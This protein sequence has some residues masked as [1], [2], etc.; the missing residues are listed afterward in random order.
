METRRKESS[1]MLFIDPTVLAY[2]VHVWE[3][4]L[5]PYML[6]SC[7]LCILGTVATARE[8]EEGAGSKLV[9]FLQD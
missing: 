4:S 3:W 7:P 2:P 6:P 1:P 9:Q 5:W 8:V